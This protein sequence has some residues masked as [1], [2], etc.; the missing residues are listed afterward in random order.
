MMNKAWKQLI[1]MVKKETILSIAVLLAICSMFFVIPDRKYMAYVDYRTLAILFSL[2]VVVAGLQK[3]EIFDRLAASIVGNISR[4]RALIMILIMLCFFFSMIITNDVA[5]II[6]CS[7]GNN[8]PEY[9][10]QK[11]GREMADTCRGHADCS[12]KSRK[13]AY[14]DRKSTKSIFVWIVGYVNYRIHEADVSICHSCCGTDY[15]MVFLEL[16]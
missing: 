12:S 6:I 9:A 2:M 8:K 15:G 1:T 11:D 14:A 10:R 4:L 13:Y 16:W 7:V 5:L 3:Q